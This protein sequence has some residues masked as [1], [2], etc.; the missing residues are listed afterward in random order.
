MQR[1]IILLFGADGQLG[2][3]LA[4]TLSLLG[5][6]VSA[7][8]PQCDICDEAALRA[9][10][11]AN[12]PT[13]IVNAAAYTAVD[14]AESEPELA[15]RV[16][17]TAPRIMAEEAQR[18]SAAMVHYSTDYVYDGNSREPYRED[19][20]P[21]P[22]SVYGLTK[23][24]GDQAIQAAG[25][26]HLILRTTWVYGHH[27]NNF[28]K[29]IL[30]LAKSRDELKVV[31]DQFGAPTWS[32][33]L[34][35]ATVIALGQMGSNMASERWTQAS[36]LYH[37]SAGGRTTWLEFAADIFARGKA[38][39]VIPEKRFELKATT[40]AVYGA[41]APRPTNSVLSNAKIQSEFGIHLPDW[42]ASFEQ[43]FNEH[44]ASLAS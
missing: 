43:M 42:R 12:K 18:L 16:N 5:Q 24:Q 8:Q 15:E 13:L 7:D 37:L 39:A 19:H 44:P 29:T 34:A 14:K 1:P 40:G 4:R 23:L 3:E 2:V 35:T 10:I 36:G 20:P 41:P 25:C 17:A 26:R 22:L 6:V 28:V 21:A 30:R 9:Y 32:R 27:G 11:R 31:A 38:A 33:A